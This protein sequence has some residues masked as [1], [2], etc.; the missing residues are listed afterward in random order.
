MDVSVALT[1]VSFKLSDIIERNKRNR[2]IEDIELLSSIDEKRNND[3]L[4]NVNLFPQEV[5]EAEKDI[6]TIRVAHFL[7]VGPSIII[8]SA[9]R[10][11]RN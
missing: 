7:I 4:V 3:F 5:G 2:E 6:E 10:Q 1:K 9:L 8:T 11:R